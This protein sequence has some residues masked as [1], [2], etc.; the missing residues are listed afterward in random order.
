MPEAFRKLQ[1]YLLKR[2]GGD[3]EMVEIIALVLH[4]DEQ[5]VLCA[6]ELALEAD[7]P[8][9][10]HILNLLHRLLDGKPV[11][12]DAV[13]APQALSLQREPRANVARYDSL[14]LKEA[15]RAS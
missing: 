9:K 8:T 14:R 13:H 15:T 6:V 12:V 11:T 3:R 4:H 1:S 10:T 5:A 2:P 7:V